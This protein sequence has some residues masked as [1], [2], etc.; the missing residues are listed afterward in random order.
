M[1]YGLLVVSI[2][3]VIMALTM[4]TKNFLSALLFKVLPFFSGVYLFIYFYIEITK[5]VIK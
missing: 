5:E 4:H 3:L 1:I 2:L